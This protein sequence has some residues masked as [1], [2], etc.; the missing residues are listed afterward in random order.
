[1]IQGNQPEQSIKAEVRAYLEIMMMMSLTN[2]TVNDS[3]IEN[4]GIT[5]ARDTKLQDLGGR[6]I[7]GVLIEAMEAIQSQ[8][9]DYRIIEVAKA[10]KDK[11]Y[12]IDA[13]GMAIA[14][15]AFDGK[16][17]PQQRNILE[18]LQRALNLTE[19]NIEEA[20]RRYGNIPLLMYITRNTL[21]SSSNVLSALWKQGF[22]HDPQKTKE[23]TSYL[24]YLVEQGY[25]PFQGGGSTPTSI[26]IH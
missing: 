26:K 17:A 4:L 6:Q 22:G 2:N 14:I 18:K 1:M 8:G 25:I 9:T 20:I 21:K 3:D 10:L 24:L 5:I 13:I 19:D 16:I 12:R 11:N 23:L 15:A 7:I